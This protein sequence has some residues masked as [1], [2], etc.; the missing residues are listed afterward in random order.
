MPLRI[1]KILI[2]I[3]AF[4][5]HSSVFSK[6]TENKN[7][8]QRYLSNYFSAL[9]SHENGDNELAIKYF[10]LT[11]IFLKDYPNYFDQYINSLV[12][13]NKV[14]DAINKKFQHRGRR[15]PPFYRV[16][17]EA[18]V[19]LPIRPYEWLLPVRPAPSACW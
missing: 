8:N 15:L 1:F 10:D 7:F 4:L 19:P 18:G 6:P 11:K 3:I 17:P 13:D 5:Y 2:I 12:L 14:I 16:N 9:I